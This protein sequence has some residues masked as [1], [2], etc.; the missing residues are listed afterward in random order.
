MKMVFNNGFL[1]I[2]IKNIINNDLA[3]LLYLIDDLQGLGEGPF[4]I[5]EK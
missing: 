3:E 5:L 1:V 4:S 2:T